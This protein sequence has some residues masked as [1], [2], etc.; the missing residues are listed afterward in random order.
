MRL[1]WTEPAL[2]D[3]RG[4]EAYIAW[5]NRTAADA[6]IGLILAAADGLVRF[7]EI[8]RPGRRTGTRELVV[9]R[10]PFILAYQRRGEAIAILRVLHGRQRWPETL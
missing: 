1:I 6:Q 8:G 5:D 7:P 3:L 10:T 4:A 2:G 9:T